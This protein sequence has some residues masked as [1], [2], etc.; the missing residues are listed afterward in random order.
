MGRK[1][2]EKSALAVSRL[3]EPGMHFVGGVDGLAL[4]VLPTGGRSWILRV[5]IGGKRR[6][7]G[8]GGYPD[9]P[10]TDAREKA[11]E[12]RSLIKKGIDPI[13]QARQQQSA[14]KASQASS[15]T[16]QEC[17]ERYIEA[18]ESAWKNAKSSQQWTNTLTQYAYPFIGSLLVRD[19]GLPQ[20]LQVLEPIWKTKGQTATRL[21]GRI[22][23]IIDWADIRGYRSG[24]VNPARWKGYLDKA[25]PDPA[26]FNPAGNQPA[27]P[28]GQTGAFMKRLRE[29]DG[30]GARALE[31]TILTAARSGMTRGAT[32][33]E[34]DLEEAIWVVP[35]ERM[36]IKRKDKK[37]AKPTRIPLSKAAIALLKS[38]PRMAGTELVFPS[39]TLKQL[40]D[41]T[42]NA[43][44]K[45]MNDAD[46][47]CWMDPNENRPVVTHGFRST[48]RDWA[49]EKTN[50]PGEM[51]EMALAHVVSDK[52]EAAYRRGD[53]LERRYR[54]MED[55]AEFCADV[56]QGG[57]VV[58]LRKGADRSE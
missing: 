2:P 39:P 40:S 52:V 15:V 10:L 37:K 33:S 54:M 51:A 13:E 17:A 1:A 11:R 3:Q 56:Q 30:M 43:V 12:A 34:I 21:R 48:F 23:A 19:V 36:K 41:M 22:E 24:G 44:I 47:N 42:L 7:M 4:Q 26:Q 32:W 50:Y 35:A 31:F 18:N 49:A 53:M 8:L 14:L 5:T 58:P 45:R 9:V 20:V 16:F 57:K 55:W 29:M 27:L 28:V 6:H 46:G 25:L 38:L